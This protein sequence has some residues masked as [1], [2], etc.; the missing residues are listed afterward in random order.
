MTFI[1][2]FQYVSYFLSSLHWLPLHILITTSE[3]GMRK[4]SHSNGCWNIQGRGNSINKVTEARNIMVYVG[5]YKL[6][7]VWGTLKFK[8][9]E[10]GKVILERQ[11]VALFM[12][13][14]CITLWKGSQY[15]FN[16]N[17]GCLTAKTVLLINFLLAKERGPLKD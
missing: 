16:L 13:R 1:V 14:L 9:R 4:L 7:C 8:K 6:L 15:F 3:I 11:V 5:K 12:V 17:L 2:C 10:F